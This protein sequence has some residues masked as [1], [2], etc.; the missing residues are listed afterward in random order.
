MSQSVRRLAVAPV[1]ALLLL[2]L[3]PAMSQAATAPFTKKVAVTGTKG[4]EGTY[5][6]QRF[7][8][9]DGKL[10]SVGTLRGTLHG[11]SVRRS[12]VRMP[13][14]L[15]NAAGSSQIPPTTGACQILNLTLNPIDLNLLG[16]RVR[17][18]RID[19]RIEAIP[20]GG[21]LGDLLCGITNLLNPGA[22]SP[23]AT[24]TRLLNALLALI[25]TGPATAAR[26]T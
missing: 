1:C 16:L 7:V 26:I 6:I 24:V 22:N 19:L 4:F 5:T 17:T 8:R 3:A 21:L 14:K 11:K 12:N 25:P 9:S 15:A 23:L 18:S 20:G 13:A 10:Y 2:M